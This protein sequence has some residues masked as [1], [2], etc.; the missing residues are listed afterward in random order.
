MLR[1][2]TFNCH[3]AYVHLLGKL[4]H[5]LDIVDG[6][7]GRV[8]ARWDERCRPVPEGAR[9][10]RLE[11]A[12]AAP[13]Y[14]VAIAHNITDLLALRT[15]AL[16]KILVLHVSLQARLREEPAAP[17]AAAMRRQLGDY[18]AAIGALAVAVS[19]AK[20]ESWGQRCPVIRPCADPDEYR[21]FE[22]TRPV[23]LRVA[24]QVMQRPERFAWPAHLAITR[25]QP[26]VLVGH[27]PEL[28]GVAPA[29]CW[30][31]LKALYREHRA[32]VHSAGD[33]LDDGYN[34]GVVE[35]MMTGMPVVSL[36]GSES[37]VADGVSGYVSDDVS[38]LNARLGELL[39]DRELALELGREA[40]RR[41]LEL[42]DVGPFVA[43]WN[44][45]IERATACFA[46][47][48]G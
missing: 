36:S 26:T 46:A 31:E 7:R 28:E 22:G 14:D 33:G 13:R 8:S 37:P 6:L 19:Q 42:F 3:E 47:R 30:A 24:N 45:A 23:A 32:Y 27:N 11:Q 2:L 5:A 25:G 35:A 48:G 38:Y 4:G 9:L 20:A 43:G 15:L 17:D 41:A 16:P 1:L 44:A 34:L 18:L 39:A 10:I 12:L 29:A 21:G 40:R